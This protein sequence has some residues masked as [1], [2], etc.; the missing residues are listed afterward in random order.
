MSRLKARRLFILDAP[1]NRSLRI[2]LVAP[3]FPPAL[4]GIQA[5]G[6]ELAKALVE[7]G[8]KVDVF[9]ERGSWD[10]R[11]AP[12]AVHPELR[13]RAYAD[14]PRLRQA[15]VD[16]WHGLNASCAWLA[17]ALAVPAFVSVHGNDVLCPYTPF[18][19]LDLR[20]RFHLPFGSRLDHWL[21]RVLTARQCRL[22]LPRAAGIFANSGAIRS[23]VISR[24]SLPENRVHVVWPAASTAFISQ[25][26]RVPTRSSAT[27]L[28]TVCRLSEPRKNIDGVLRALSLL[29]SNAPSWRYTIVGDGRLRGSLESLAHELKL[30]D[31]VTFLGNLESNALIN[32]LRASDVFVLPARTDPTSIEGFGIVYLEAAAC[33]VP[34]VAAT[35]GGAND[36]V[37]QGKS[38][39]ILPDAEP[40]T[41]AHALG[42]ILRREWVVS[43]TECQEHARNY[44]WKKAAT[45]VSEKYLAVLDAAA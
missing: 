21:S 36:A 40:P 24:Y 14:A 38:G 42:C 10:N 2:G 31:R 19:G 20:S 4:G 44:S 29:P 37:Q 34:S 33:G 7:L 23:L 17:S 18:G 5:Y 6:W 15:S 35:G 8:H 27:E 22:G 13:L 9:V 26:P 30:A 12:F 1:Q 39:W 32:R 41:V 25:P 3:E 28:I 45:R 11:P 16:V 43:S